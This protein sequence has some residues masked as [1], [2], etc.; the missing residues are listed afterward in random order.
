MGFRGRVGGG[1][2]EM[3]EGDQKVE[4]KKKEWD[5]TQVHLDESK[6]EGKVL[7][8]GFWATISRVSEVV[9]RCLGKGGGHRIQEGGAPMGREDE[10]ELYHN[11]SKD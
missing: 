1:G 6:R 8:M 5:K 11:F 4:Q 3:G 9:S 10:R 7:F 2:G